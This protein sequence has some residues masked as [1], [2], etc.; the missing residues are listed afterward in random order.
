MQHASTAV[1]SPRD[2]AVARQQSTTPDSVASNTAPDD[3]G[4]ERGYIRSSEGYSQLVPS[5]PAGRVDSIAAVAERRTGRVCDYRSGRGTNSC[6][7]VSTISCQPLPATDGSGVI[8]IR[9]VTTDD[10]LYEMLS[11]QS[12]DYE[13]KLYSWMRCHIVWN[14][15][16]VKVRLG[17][18]DITRNIE[19][20]SYQDYIISNVYIHP[21]FNSANLQNDI[22]VIKL[23][24]QIPLGVY[25]NIN[26]ACLSR[27]NAAFT[28]QRC[29][30]AGW[31]TDAFGPSGQY[32][33]IEKEA[34][35]PVLGWSDCQAKLQATRLGSQFQFN[36]NSFICA[37]GEEGYDACTGDGGSAL[38]CEVNGQHYVAGIVAWGIGCA[39]KGVPGVYVNVPSYIDWINQKISQT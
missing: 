25:P 37:G 13:D 30:V 39:D 28:G 36:P 29:I 2:I 20:Y 31:G 10:K 21:H 3:N 26:P 4:P 17:D 27:Q 16:G 7:C 15:P 23:Y 6:G 19:P 35:V 5:K 1:T 33:S 34:T 22:A 8:D 38:V 12:S 9:I 14:C 11:S 32:Q 18:W 24:Q